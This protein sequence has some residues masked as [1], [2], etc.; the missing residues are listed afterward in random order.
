MQP[1]CENYCRGEDQYFRRLEYSTRV[2]WCSVVID[3]TNDVI[4]LV[5]EGQ[6]EA[7]ARKTRL[8]IT[9][10]HVRDTANLHLLLQ[11]TTPNSEERRFLTLFRASRAFRNRTDCRHGEGTQRNS[12]LQRAAEEMHCVS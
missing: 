10:I 5:E 11:Q 8:Y 9:G 1:W 12:S 7:L 4:E 6:Q 3:Q 2:T